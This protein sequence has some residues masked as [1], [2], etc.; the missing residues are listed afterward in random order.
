MIMV[1]IDLC[2]KFYLNGHTSNNPGIISNKSASSPNN[3]GSVT[4]ALG[5]SPRTHT[6][7]HSI[8][9]LPKRKKSILKFYKITCIASVTAFTCAVL[10]D[11]GIGIHYFHSGIDVFHTK[12]YWAI[13]LTNVF[14][15]IAMIS[16]YIFM[17]GRL[18]LTFKASASKYHLRYH[19]LSSIYAKHPQMNCKYFLRDI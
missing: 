10:I 7:S 19:V 13:V 6:S 18:Y 3:D 17:F 15:G 14:Y 2:R 8:T 1:L 16:L 11:F 12:D 5:S 4:S 9:N